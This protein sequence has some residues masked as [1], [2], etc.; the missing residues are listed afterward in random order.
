MSFLQNQEVL[1]SMRSNLLLDENEVSESCG[2]RVQSL[3]ASPNLTPVLSILKKVKDL[4]HQ[5]S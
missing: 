3:A 5:F 4:G 1:R 2:R